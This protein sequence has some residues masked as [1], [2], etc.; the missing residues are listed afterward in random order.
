MPL[1]PV[2]L[3]P[4]VKEGGLSDLP[5]APDLFSASRA[6]HFL[7]WTRLTKYL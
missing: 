5:A 6:L 2:Q 7:G 4:N 1:L 3:V